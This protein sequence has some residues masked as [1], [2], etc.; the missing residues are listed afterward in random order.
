MFIFPTRVL[1]ALC[2]IFY[3]QNFLKKTNATDASG[4]IVLGDIG[5]HLQ[6]E[7]G[8]LCFYMVLI[9]THDYR[10]LKVNLTFKIFPVSSR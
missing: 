6:Q 7:V 10:M 4:N 2:F 3:L 9:D 8:D 5:V 1:S